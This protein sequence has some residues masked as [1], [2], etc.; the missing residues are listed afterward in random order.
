MRVEAGRDGGEKVDFYFATIKCP[1][2]IDK[3]YIYPIKKYIPVYLYITRKA[4]YRCEQCLGTS[5]SATLSRL[6]P[7]LRMCPAAARIVVQNSKCA[8]KFLAAFS[9]LPVVC[10]KRRRP[11]GLSMQPTLQRA[12][13][14]HAR[15]L[16]SKPS[17]VSLSSRA[18][19]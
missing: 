5:S 16:S 11:A 13:T 6:H 14:M 8:T 19:C 4:D 3:K 1:V 2:G 10:G 7:G 17:A 12:C 15:W 18:V 9:V